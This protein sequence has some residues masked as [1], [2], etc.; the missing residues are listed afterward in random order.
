MN[1]HHLDDLIIDDPEPVSIKS[2]SLLTI[3]ALL[4]VVLIIGLVLWA[5]LFDSSSPQ[6]DNS[7]QTHQSKPLAP[8]LIPL[9]RPARQTKTAEVKTKTEKITHKPAQKT[10]QTQK[11][12]QEAIQTPQPKPAQ[13][14]PETAPAPKEPKQKNIKPVKTAQPEI[15]SPKE[16]PAGKEIIKNADKT[17]YYVQVG[18][19]KR[20]PSPKFIKKLKE[21]GFTFIT[22]TSKGIRRVRV[23]PYDNYQEAKNALP[24]IKAKLGVDGLIVKY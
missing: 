15:T 8:D 10:V 23:G 18:A 2:K 19:F 22:K 17:I 16:T 13:K 7:A 11:P 12:K 24:E 5:L 9:D 1:D 6:S 21:N 4:I 20:D 14:Q 3:I